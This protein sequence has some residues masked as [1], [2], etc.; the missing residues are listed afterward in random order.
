M[1]M[2]PRNADD[3][4][5]RFSLLNEGAVAWS[6]L[7]QRKMQMLAAWWWRCLQL[8]DAGTDVAVDADVCCL[9]IQ[10]SNAGTGAVVLLQVGLSAALSSRSI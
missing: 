3:N 6:G 7:L 1:S 4:P 5:S 2:R 9:V 8:G 10:V